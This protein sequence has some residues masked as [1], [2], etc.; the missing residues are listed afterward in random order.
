M[1]LAILGRSIPILAL[2]LATSFILTGCNKNSKDLITAVTEN[3]FDSVLAELEKG[4]NPDSKNKSKQSALHIAIDNCIRFDKQRDAVFNKAVELAD[5]KKLGSLIDSGLRSS[6]SALDKANSRH[7]SAGDMKE[8]SAGIREA[9]HVLPIYLMNADLKNA[10]KADPNSIRK[11]ILETYSKPDKKGTL[12]VA[13]RYLVRTAGS[14]DVL[15]QPVTDFAQAANI[16]YWILLCG[17]DAELLSTDKK[18]AKKRA[19]EAE[20]IS[21]RQSFARAQAVLAEKGVEESLKHIPQARE[22]L[23]Q[24]G[25]RYFMDF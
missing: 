18:T 13:L 7:E 22:Q 14:E 4:A 9:E 19:E 8:M 6:K 20:L 10:Y 16:L 24:A 25:K 12:K 3:N 11:V 1:Q 5:V 17:A 23:K 15:E 21:L 2:V